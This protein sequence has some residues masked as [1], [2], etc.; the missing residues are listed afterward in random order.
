MFA[1]YISGNHT[2]C[3]FQA[4]ARGSCQKK[5]RGHGS[6]HGGSHRGQR[7]K[8][9]RVAM[10]TSI[11][12]ILVHCLSGIAHQTFGRCCMPCLWSD[13]TLYCKNWSVYGVCR[14]PSTEVYFMW[15][16]KSVYVFICSWRGREV[17]DGKANKALMACM[18]RQDSRRIAQAERAAKAKSKEMRKR[19]QQAEKRSRTRPE[20]A[21]GSQYEAGG[22]IWI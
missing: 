11:F 19:R 1:L 15:V 7:C 10:C 20:T 6:I 14:I 12:L 18:E 3:I 8:W 4:P 5:N 13:W 22:H 17:K 16:H 9:T 21:E 2:S